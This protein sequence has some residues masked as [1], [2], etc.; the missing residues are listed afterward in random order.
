M[1]EGESGHSRMSPFS[2]TQVHNLLHLLLCRTEGWVAGADCLAARLIALDVTGKRAVKAE[3]G[4]RMMVVRLLCAGC[5][6]DRV[7]C[8]KLGSDV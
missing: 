7:R 6:H 8:G 4:D 2:Q 3:M 1:M 5:P